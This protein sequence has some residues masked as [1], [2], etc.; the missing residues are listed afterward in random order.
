MALAIPDLLRESS[1]CTVVRDLR[2]S[3]PMLP[4]LKLG[5]AF[6]LESKV[7]GVT[8]RRR[9]PE[10]EQTT[11]LNGIFQA[12]EGVQIGTGVKYRVTAHLCDP[13]QSHAVRLSCCIAVWMIQR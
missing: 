10:I 11:N 12:S 5:N 1:V 2:I 8:L 9:S 13:S 7:A 4:V 6:S 3:S